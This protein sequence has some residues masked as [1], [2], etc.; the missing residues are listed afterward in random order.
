MLKGKAVQPESVRMCLLY[1]PKDGRVVHTHQ[2]VTLPGGRHVTDGEV[3]A[4]AF[5]RAAQT[6]KDTSKLR[7]LHVSPADH[8]FS[9][10]YRV[11]RK[12]KKLVKVPM[13]PNPRLGRPL[14]GGRGSPRRGSKGNL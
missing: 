1:D 6:G 3:E 5:S 2:V 10:I 11:D 12:S 8:D 4:R 13:P 9:S 14:Q 7:A